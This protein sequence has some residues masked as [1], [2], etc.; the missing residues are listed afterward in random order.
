M[1]NS[2]SIENWKISTLFHLCTNNYRKITSDICVGYME[3][4]ATFHWKLQLSTLSFIVKELVLKVG[5]MENS[6]TFDRKLED[7]ISTL[8]HS[9]TNN[10]RERTSDICVES[11]IYGKF[12]YLWSKIA[13]YRLFWLFFIYHL[14]NYCKT[15]DICIESCIY[16]KLVTFV[17]KV[18]YMKNFV[19]F[20]RKL[21]GIDSFSFT[22]E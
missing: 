22:Y 7:T 15:S 6:A 2:V 3:N 17:L 18:V 1:E 19:T 4:F 9:C 16:G 21:E 12:Y 20:E 8:F 5:Y 11:W 13:K 14:N 10:Y